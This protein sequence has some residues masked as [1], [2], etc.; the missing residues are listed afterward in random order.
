MTEVLFY[1]LQGRPLEAVLPPLLEKSLER[2]WRV[3]V[4]TGS[5][6]RRDALD[7]HLWTFRDDSFLPHGTASDGP[8]ADQPVFL[9]E[10]Q[11]NPNGA[12]VRFLVDRAA[13]PDLAPY[14]RAVFVFDGT[15]EEALA[16]ARLRWKEGKAAGFAVTY[17]QQSSNG[18]WERKA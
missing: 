16:E 1:H 3:V 13:P 10:G 7:A 12:T 14:E 5:R 9:T 17:W 2:G 8:G 6:E 18:R 15:D 4:Q 11:D